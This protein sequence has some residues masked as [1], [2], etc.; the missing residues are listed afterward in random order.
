M[1]EDGTFDHPNDKFQLESSAMLDY[2]GSKEFAKGQAFFAKVFVL[3]LWEELA[4][5]IPH[6]Q[7]YVTRINQNIQRYNELE[8]K[9]DER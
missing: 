7:P 4:T 3:P 5:L 1:N 8:A 9:A 6:F 2:N